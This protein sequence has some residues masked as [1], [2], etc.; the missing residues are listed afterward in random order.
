MPWPRPAWLRSAQQALEDPVDRRRR[1]KIVLSARFREVVLA[2]QA[3]VAPGDS[4]PLGRQVRSVR[5]DG[6]EMLEVASGPAST[7][8]STTGTTDGAGRRDRSR[9]T[10]L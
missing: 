1:A 4:R 2:D 9:G 8:S 10:C 7:A 3:W 6:I 5:V